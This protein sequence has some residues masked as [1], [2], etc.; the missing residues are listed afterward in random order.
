V[1]VVVPLLYLSIAGFG[2]EP[3]AS[4]HIDDLSRYAVEQALPKHLFDRQDA[5]W[6]LESGQV[7]ADPSEQLSPSILDG[8]QTHER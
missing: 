7:V 5:A 6:R 8:N 1:F 3:G 4:A 2:L